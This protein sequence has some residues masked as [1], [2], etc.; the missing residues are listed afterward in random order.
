MLWLESVEI[1]VR[2][3]TVI[4]QRTP[5]Q[6]IITNVFQ[7][8]GQVTQNQEKNRNTARAAMAVDTGPS[9]GIWGVRHFASDIGTAS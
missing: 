5:A 3:F 1:A 9:G 8:N 4:H 6:C 7:H 2:D